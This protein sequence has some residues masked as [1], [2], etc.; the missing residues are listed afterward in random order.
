MIFKKNK[1]FLTITEYTERKNQLIDEFTGTKSR[2]NTLSSYLDTSQSQKYIPKEKWIPPR[3]PNF[4]NCSEER[5]IFH[6][7]NAKT[8][9][10]SQKI[11][12]VEIENEPFA[13]GGLRLAFH[14]KF[15][16][17]KD[18]Q[19]FYFENTPQVSTKSVS[20]PKKEFK[21]HFV[22]KT[23]IDPY[24]DRESY[25]ADSEMQQYSVINRLS[26]FSNS[27]FFSHKLIT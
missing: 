9:T 17:E 13:R 20:L 1:G 21:N 15:L 16:D 6:Q 22:A 5:A 11:S 2:K 23:S 3:I 4:E 19:E 27:N 26:I 12:K 10:W 14:M 8:S 24:E 25:F 18:A 7:F